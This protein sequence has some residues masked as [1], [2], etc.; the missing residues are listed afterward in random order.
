MSSLNHFKLQHL[1]VENVFSS[2]CAKAI[3][4]EKT[5][6]SVRLARSLKQIV[7]C[8]STFQESRSWVYSTICKSMKQLV[9]FNLNTPNYIIITHMATIYNLSNICLKSCN[10]NHFFFQ[11]LYFITMS[12]A[13]LT[14]YFNFFSVNVPRLCNKLPNKIKICKNLKIMLNLLKDFWLL[15]KGN[16]ERLVE[17]DLVMKYCCVYVWVGVC[18]LVALYVIRGEKC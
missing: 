12:K 1:T 15:S 11:L 8:N 14:I 13:K 10:K 7:S 9:T 3:H 17:C 5:I 16:D 18:R 2:K 6:N 4:Y